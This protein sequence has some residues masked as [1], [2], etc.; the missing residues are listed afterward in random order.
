MRHI[1]I[2]K[3]QGLVLKESRPFELYLRVVI[4]TGDRFRIRLKYRRRKRQTVL[5]ADPV[6]Q[7]PIP[8]QGLLRIYQGTRLFTVSVFLS[9][10]KRLGKCVHRFHGELIQILQFGHI[11][12]LQFSEFL[13]GIR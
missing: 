6:D 7:L 9:R 2:G 11:R 13:L 10:E 5:L 12:P 3:I 8:F 4:L 1:L